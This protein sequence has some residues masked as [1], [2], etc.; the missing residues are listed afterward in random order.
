MSIKKLPIQK[1]PI[2]KGKEKKRGKS[3][4]RNAK[5][6]KATQCAFQSSVFPSTRRFGRGQKIKREK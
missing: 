4:L 3:N 2:K 5:T 6:M 1:W